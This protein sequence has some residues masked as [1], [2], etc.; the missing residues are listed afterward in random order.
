MIF[1]FVDPQ[2]WLGFS[3]RIDGSMVWWNQVPVPTP[4][5]E[6]RNKYFRKQGIDPSR[7]VAG[8]CAHSTNVR[9]VGEEDAGTYIPNSDSLITNHAN[10]F[11]SITASDCMPVYFCDSKQRAVGIA[12]AGWRGLVDGLLERVVEQMVEVFQSRPGDLLV[13]LGSHIRVCHFEIK[14]DVSRQLD[15]EH[16]ESHNGCLF[17]NLSR[18]A[19]ARLMKSGVQTILDSSVCT[20]CESDR[21]YSSRHDKK[22]PLE[23]AVAS[24]GYRL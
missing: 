2:V 14:E 11:L 17:G 6:N 3:E 15:S 10:L 12:H 9:L 5:Q 13:L 20:M 21:L 19:Q 18:E 1:P 22:D 7:V 24:I 8:G 23:G 4:V 16:V